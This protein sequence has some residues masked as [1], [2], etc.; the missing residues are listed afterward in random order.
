MNGSSPLPLLPLTDLDLSFCAELEDCF[1]RE[2]SP[3]PPPLK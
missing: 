3:G 2:A 1:L